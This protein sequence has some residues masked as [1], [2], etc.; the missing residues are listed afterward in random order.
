ML[1]Q[2]EQRLHAVTASCTL[3]VQSGQVQGVVASSSRV[4]ATHS[5]DPRLRV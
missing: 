3:G 5:M 1:C 4:L 2:E